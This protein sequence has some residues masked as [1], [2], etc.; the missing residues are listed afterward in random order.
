MAE[1]GYK[2][3]GWLGLQLG[4]SLW[5]GC[6]QVEMVDRVLPSLLQR[7]KPI[8][9]GQGGSSTA[10]NPLSARKGSIAPSVAAAGS[11][12]PDL[13]RIASEMEAMANEIKQLRLTQDEL[14]S[15]VVMLEKRLDLQQQQ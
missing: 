14:R 8:S 3:N 2:P 1:E 5:I 10:D 11:G 7:A 15:R 4:K 12:G 6:W 9:G 13:V